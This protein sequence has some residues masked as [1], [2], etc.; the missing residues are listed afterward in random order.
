[1]TYIYLNTDKF[2]SYLSVWIAITHG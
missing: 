1:L 2:K